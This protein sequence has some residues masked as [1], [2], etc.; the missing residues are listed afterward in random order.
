M[1]NKRHTITLCLVTRGPGV[2][3]EGRLDELCL[4]LQFRAALTVVLVLNG[5]WHSQ[6]GWP[7]WT[8]GKSHRGQVTLYCVCCSLSDISDAP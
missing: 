6:S 7:Y 2:I 5:G 4:R 1:S 8:R 3:S